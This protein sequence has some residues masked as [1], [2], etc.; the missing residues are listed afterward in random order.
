MQKNARS[1]LRLIRLVVQAFG[2]VEGHTVRGNSGRGMADMRA[3]RGASP[4]SGPGEA[5]AEA[6][7]TKRSKWW[8][9]R[10]CDPPRAGAHRQSTPDGTGGVHHCQAWNS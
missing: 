7:G 5:E 9:S 6:E 10:G 4:H 8:A 2:N 3:V 1:D